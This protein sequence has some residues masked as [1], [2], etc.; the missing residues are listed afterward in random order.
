M[1]NPGDLIVFL[2]VLAIVAVFLKVVHWFISGGEDAGKDTP[3][4]HREW[5]EAQAP[6]PPPGEPESDEIL[7]SQSR[8]R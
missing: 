5:P 4:P 1:I 6:P 7:P 8:S 2:A 3:A